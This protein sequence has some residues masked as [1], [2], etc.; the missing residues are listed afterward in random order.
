MHR[1][2]CLLV[3]LVF[4]LLVGH[5]IFAPSPL[6]AQGRNQGLT[7]EQ[8]QKDEE[9]R[10]SRE[11]DKLIEKVALAVGFVG[12]LSFVAAV[13]SV[14][15]LIDLRR[16][17]AL[18]FLANDLGMKFSARP[19]DEE[20][21]AF[22]KL[23]LSQV[24]SGASWRNL[25]VGQVGG[26][27]VR[28]VDYRCRLGSSNRPLHRSKT[29][30]VIFRNAEPGLPDFTLTPRVGWKSQASVL[31]LMLQSYPEVKIGTQPVHPFAS[32]YWVGAKD[33]KAL[34]ALFTP[35]VLDFFVE[36]KNWNV[37]ALAHHVA[38]YRLESLVKPKDY[39]K[40]VGKAF[41][42]VKAL[43]GRHSP[44]TGE[45]RSGILKEST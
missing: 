15:W 6:F 36:N 20:L 33:G 18:A 14:P 4:G 27:N 5:D 24:G 45:G 29:T 13:F 9:Y 32:H 3:V 2:H 38:I 12:V 31:N 7:P 25:M 10:R 42:V 28:L 8:Q 21:A 23:S 40:R 37:E 22:S 17:K 35:K 41:A 44:K 16:T 30:V 43:T 34:A 1:V 39:P 19:T 26:V 11:R